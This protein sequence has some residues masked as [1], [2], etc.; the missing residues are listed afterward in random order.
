MPN[1]GGGHLAEAG[2]KY[3]PHRRRAWR[4]GWRL[5]VAGAACLV[6]GLL[7]NLFKDKAT[8]TIISLN[9]ELKAAP[10]HQSPPVLLEYEI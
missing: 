4:I 10:G 6:H 3:H 1:G 2:M 7:P 8:R 9:D 5:S